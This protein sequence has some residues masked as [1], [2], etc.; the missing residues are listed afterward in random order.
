MP[1]R[2]KIA[3]AFA[4]V[5]IFWGSTFLGIRFA[6]ATL[7]PLLMA[8]ARFIAAGIIL[9]AWSLRRG[10][11]PPTVAQWG[12]A[13]LIGGLLFLGGNGALS[14][15]VQW[16]PSGVASLLAA[17]GAFWM[18]LLDW[19]QPEG[20]RPSRRIVLGLALGLA[21][22][23]VLIGPARLAGSGPVYAGAAL[24]VT[25]GSFA[26]AAGSVLSRRVPLP[27]SSIQ[28]AAMETLAG[29]VLLSGLGLA[30]GERQRL[31]WA[32]ISSTSILAVLYLIVF[33]SLVGFT[34]YNWLLGVTS[35]ARVSTYAYVN[36]V[37]AVFLGW[38]VGREELT[39][40]TLLAATVIV[41]A[42]ALIISDRSRSSSQLAEAS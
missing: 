15:A 9:Y 33:G 25:A 5:Y 17:T 2:R 23:A 31:V 36:P 34:A 14:W 38:A 1:S 37:I 32:S 27:A 20:R 24:V 6:V 19:A 16:V 29:G 22:V 18:V 11:P 21:G 4:L 35:S 26:W 41:T 13:A 40:R 42:V 8:G 12:G 3:L 28:A 39:L 10:A 7:P 30:L